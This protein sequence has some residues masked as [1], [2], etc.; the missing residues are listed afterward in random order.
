MVNQE[1]EVPIFTV[2]RNRGK[3]VRKE[4]C[5]T[6]INIGIRTGGAGQAMA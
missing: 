2:R 5:Y 1:Y 6:D 4:E 3:V